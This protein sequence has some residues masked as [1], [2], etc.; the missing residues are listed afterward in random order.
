MQCFVYST[1]LMEALKVREHV[2]NW[3]DDRIGELAKD[4]KDGFAK[5]DA[6][7]EMVDQKIDAGFANVDEKFERLYRMLFGGMVVIVGALTGVP[8]LGG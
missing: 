1:S 7:F 5:V 4:V 3:N 8:A 6:R 2:D